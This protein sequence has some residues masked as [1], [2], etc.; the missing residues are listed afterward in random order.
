MS[1]STTEDLARYW[2]DV[3][4][5]LAEA[6]REGCVALVYDF[7]GVSRAPTFVMAYLIVEERCVCC[8]LERSHPWL[9]RLLFREALFI[10]KV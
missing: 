6:K 8:L 5:F 4:G 1:E 3:V 7:S 2:D 10:L 9:G